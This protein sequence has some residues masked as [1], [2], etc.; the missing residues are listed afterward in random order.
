MKY[1]YPR[2]PPPQAV[3]VLQELT[4]LTVQELQ[5]RSDIQ[6]PQS[7]WYP[8][9]PN[10][11]PPEHLSGLQAR[12]REIAGEFGYPDLMNRRSH[13]FIEF[14]RAVTAEIIAEMGIVP[15]DAAHEGVWSFLSLV[16]LPDVALWRYPNTSGRGDYERIIGRPRNVFRR[17]WWRAFA[18]GPEIS[19]QLLED[20]AVGIMERSS[21]GG[22]PRIARTLAK[23]H[24]AVLAK[25]PLLS[26]AELMRQVTK[27]LRRLSVVVTLGVLDDNALRGLIGE[28]L[29]ESM[30]A[31][32]NSQNI[33]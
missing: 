31:L 17:L 2:L 24:L 16:L 28:V 1:A 10:R 27:R 3:S 30:D 32:S 19:S 9:A 20:E 25:N 11:V 6:H 13:R 33:A 14:D 8:V 29:T 22:N 23:E 15:A 5:V 12:F 18:L 26:R 21:L 7:E 4:P